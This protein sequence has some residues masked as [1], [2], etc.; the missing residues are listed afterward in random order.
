MS[1]E[2]SALLVVLAV[3]SMAGCGTA[4]SAGSS[5]PKA[6]QQ[7]SNAYEKATVKWVGDDPDSGFTRHLF[8][9]DASE[10]SSIATYSPPRKPLDLLLSMN[11]RYA[12]TAFYASKEDAKE[13]RATVDIYDSVGDDMA[14]RFR[15]YWPSSG[16]MRWTSCQEILRV[17]SSGSDTMEASLHS[18]E[19]KQVWGAGATALAISPD[20]TFLL[21]YVP[22]G[23][24]LAAKGQV[25]VYDLHAGKTALRYAPQH[26]VLGIEKVE[27]GSKKLTFRYRDRKRQRRV[28]SA[29]LISK[30]CANGEK[31]SR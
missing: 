25:I 11:R 4:V 17:W 26:E 15:T 5:A 9:L 19:G 20:E 21:S 24:S 12:L 31:K 30:G 7:L 18:V 27:W 2:P 22:T 13:Q 29:P 28:H 3:A 14:G 6:K 10:C 1:V 16:T 8:C 23:A